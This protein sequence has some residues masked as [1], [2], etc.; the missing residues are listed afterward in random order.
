MFYDLNVQWTSATDPELPRTLAFLAELGYD[1]VALDHTFNGKLPPELTCPIPSPL[2][3][4]VPKNLTILR[5]LTLPL[6]S[7]LSNAR[8]K[9][10]SAS[11]D[12]LALRPTDEKTLQA[13]CSTLDA[14]I[15][16]LDLS[17]R[18]GFPFKFKP[19]SEGVKRGVR[20][21]V[22]YSQ[23]VS[24]DPNA[25]RNVIS[26]CTS[27]IRASRGR[28]LMV[29]SEARRAVECR[30]PWDVV[31]LLAVWGLSQER[32]YEAVSKEARSVV[33]MAG[34]KRSGYRG[35]VD[36]V[37]GGE[38]T[39]RTDDVQDKDKVVKTNGEKTTVAKRKA[40]ELKSTPA[41]EGQPMSKRQM[42]RNAKAAREAANAA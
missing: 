5:R 4:P 39:Q 23:G 41:K 28:G 34:L 1:V 22:C 25:R 30:G 18:F 19:L 38:D 40:E 20:I 3:F 21:E 42:K 7:P 33:V 13:C 10:L 29:S 16:S 17:Q 26:N 24:G 35:V 2:P 14:D 27:L 32:A 12:L 11:Y 9:S 15:V 8:L 6:T 37:Y 31:N 36:V